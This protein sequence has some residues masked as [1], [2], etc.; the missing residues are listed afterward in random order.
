MTNYN[1]MTIR[2]KGAKFQVFKMKPS[3][4]HAGAVSG[5]GFRRTTWA[6]SAVAS[7]RFTGSYEDCA[8]FIAAQGAEFMS[9]HGLPV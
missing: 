5:G 2:S 7:P 1:R 3:H 4:E 8:A 6:V 9:E